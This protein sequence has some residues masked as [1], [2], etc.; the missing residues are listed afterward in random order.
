MLDRNNKLKI[1][2][3]YISLAVSILILIIKVGAY[4][5]TGS[6]AIFAD[7]LE[8][9]VHII[10]T[11]MA[12]YSIIL[13]TKPPDETHLYGH[14]NIEY[15]SA[16][17][18][19]LFI[20]IAAI[21]IIYTSID[22]IISGTYIEQLDYGTFL[23]GAAGLIN[24]VLGNYL[25][26]KGK[27]T[28]SIALVADGKHVLTDS[29]TSIGIVFGLILVIFTDYKIIDPIIALFVAFNIIYTGIKLLRE[30]VG[31]L[32]NETDEKILRQIIETLN[33]KRKDYWIDLHQLRFWKSAERVFIDF[34]LTLPYYFTI[35][36]SHSQ[37]DN[38]AEIIKNEIPNSQVKIHFDYCNEA[39]CKYC[40]YEK[41]KVRKEDFSKNIPWDETKLLGDAI[42][43]STHI[44]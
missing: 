15:F 43:K 34:H 13:S 17:V 18:E 6:S 41:C 28:N 30:S 27:D 42:N 33:S 35:R 39:L 9:V 2:A 23:I 5:L 7:A 26:R 21:A 29:F 19:G 16:G 10:A 14:G 24:V 31:G 20:I 44:S 4:F 3:I 32:M 1:K 36:E 37:D 8:S 22:H 12:V 38:I 40:R 11:T 25:V